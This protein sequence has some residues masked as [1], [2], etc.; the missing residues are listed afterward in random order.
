MAVSVGA[1]SDV[2][3]RGAS[4]D[5]PWPGQPPCGPPQLPGRL[6]SQPPVSLLDKGFKKEGRAG[7]GS[8]GRILKDRRTNE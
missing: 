3:S 5:G 2:N 6:L 4:P 1:Q 8:L 7:S